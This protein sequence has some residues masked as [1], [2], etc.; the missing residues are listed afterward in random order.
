M[1]TVVEMISELLDPLSTPGEKL[2]SY[3]GLLVALLPVH[4]DMYPSEMSH[5]C[6]WNLVE[7]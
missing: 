4:A 2:S 1:E 6:L 5:C 3:I 7:C